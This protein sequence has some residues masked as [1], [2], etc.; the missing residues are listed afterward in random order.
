MALPAPDTFRGTDQS[1]PVNTGPNTKKPIDIKSPQFPAKV[2]DLTTQFEAKKST[3]PVNAELNTKMAV[4]NGDVQTTAL[5][6]LSI[7]LQEIC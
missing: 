4:R 2:R 1:P 6:R 3:Q 7:Q 5:R